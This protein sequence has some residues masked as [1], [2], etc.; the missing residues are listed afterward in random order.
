MDES[1]FATDIM[2]P[3]F[4]EAAGKIK[5]LTIG[6]I[7][8]QAVEETAG[9]SSSFE[10]VMAYEPAPSVDIYGSPGVTLFFENE[11]IQISATPIQEEEDIF[12]YRVVENGYE[13][14][15]FVAAMLPK[16]MEFFPFL[17][18]M[19]DRMR[20]GDSERSDLVRSYE[21]TRLP[22]LREALAQLSMRTVESEFEG[23]R[24][25]I[26][27]E[28]GGLIRFYYDYTIPELELTVLT[29]EFDGKTHYIPEY[30]GVSDAYF[31]GRILS[32]LSGMN[33]HSHAVR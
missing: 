19:Y 32:V 26:A 11:T 6:D 2:I 3:S 25:A 20:S 24:V 15:E 21:D 16:E 1:S 22:A 28:E 30:R 8:K 10:P 7:K 5:L 9:E 13:D 33:L 31:Y 23:R 4:M 27:I 17:P 29:V 12:L 14:W 18:I